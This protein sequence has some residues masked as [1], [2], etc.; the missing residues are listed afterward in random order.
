MIEPAR[1]VTVLR[2][3]RVFTAALEGWTEAVAYRGARVEAVGTL[4]DLLDR[5]PDAR[6]IDVGGRTVLPGLI[7]A[8]N[9]F[10]ATG[11]SLAAVDARYPGV[12]SIED[13]VANVASAATTAPPGAWVTAFGFDDAKYEGAL[14]RWDLDRA[15]ADRPIGVYHVSGHHVVVNS[16]ALADRGLDEATPDPPGGRLVRDDG[17]LNGWCLDAAMN[18]ILPVAVDIGSHGPNFHTVTTL[19]ASVAAV[20]RAAR[21]F[22]AA[23]LT[24]VCDAQ[25]TSRELAAYR[26]ADRRGSLGVRTVCMPLSHQLETFRALGLA[27]P[28]GDDRLRIGALKIY[29]DGSL[30]GG[31][32]A[33]AEPYGEHGEFAGSMYRSP[34]ELRE[35]I[36][37]AHLDGWQIGVHVQGDRAMTAVL[38]GLEAA[39][40]AAPRDH[41]HRLEHAGYPTPAL[42]ERIARLGAITVNQTNYLFDSGDEFLVRLGERAHGLMPLRDELAAGIPVVLSSDSD[43][44]SYRPLDTIRSATER[45]TRSGAPIGAAQALTLDEALRAHTITA[46]YA[47]GMEDRI[48]S[49]EPGKLADIVVIDGDLPAADDIAALGVWLTVLDGRVEHAVEPSL[50]DES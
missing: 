50:V 22:L 33:F 24:T 4:S 23:G 11:E 27:G 41:R 25:V 45:R 14:T 43:V 2:G 20:E 13:L 5:F 12:A 18:L 42:L 29:A 16:R 26:E 19:D 9:H 10:L 15:A 37:A 35:L 1:P 36:V 17:R 47:L 7:D 3:G 6:Q 21:A 49:L 38:D 39:V 8:H 48:G 46:A 34:A 28:F 40:A 31:T 32:A 30:I 44:T